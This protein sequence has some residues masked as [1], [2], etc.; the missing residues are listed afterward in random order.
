MKGIINDH[1]DKKRVLDQLMENFV[2]KDFCFFDESKRR[3]LLWC[4]FINRNDKVFPTEE[5][6]NIKLPKDHDVFF[7]SERVEELYK[8]NFGEICEYVIQLEPWEEIDAEI[9]DDS[10]KWVIAITHEDISL[11]F[12]LE[13]L[14][15]AAGMG[16]VSGT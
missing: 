12:G 11:I 16:K 3:N 9:F 14:E 15:N 10:M 4:H 13:E 7:Y 5:L 8:T 1:I 2:K 6:V